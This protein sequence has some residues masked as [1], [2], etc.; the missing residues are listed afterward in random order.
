MNSHN[1]EVLGSI[2]GRDKDLASNTVDSTEVCVYVCLCVCLCEDEFLH[3]YV[4]T[5]I[6]EW[7][8]SYYIK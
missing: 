2:L 5:N 8:Y 1:S 3:V 7:N 4:S 6:S